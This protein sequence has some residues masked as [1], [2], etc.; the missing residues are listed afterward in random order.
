MHPLDESHF[1][2][3]GVELKGDVVE[4][5]LAALRGHEF[6][7]LTPEVTRRGT[8]LPTLFQ[9]LCNLCQLVQYIDAAVCTGRVKSSSMEVT[10]L[11]MDEEFQSDEFMK[12]W[13]VE[14]K[15]GYCLHAILNAF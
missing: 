11:K 7:D 5:F 6:F 8:S 14:S 3:R 2:N 1:T 12:A 4:V 10:M 9:Q 13:T 15:R